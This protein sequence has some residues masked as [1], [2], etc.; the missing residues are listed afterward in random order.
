MKKAVVDASVAVKWAV[1]EAFSDRAEYLL[2]DGIDLL[3]PAHWLA[4]VGCAL[5]AKSAIHGVMNRQQAIERI[6]WIRG[7]T[8][9]A[10]PLDGLILAAS[11]IAFDLHVTT[12]DAL[13]LALAEQSGA[14]LVT[15]DRKFHD[16]VAAIS[17]FAGLL[18]WVGDLPS[19][20]GA[21]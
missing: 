19:G 4:E 14:P 15:A 6:E 7:L 5:S 1:P 8:V 10:T 18:I 2:T 12:Y 9:E 17:R 13:Y 16:K 11:R 3:A 20:N 21:D